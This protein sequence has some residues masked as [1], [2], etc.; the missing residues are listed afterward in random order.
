MKKLRTAV[1]GLGRIGWAFHVPKIAANDGFELVAAVDTNVERLE[2]FKEKYGGNGYTDLKEMLDAENPDLVVIASPTHLHKEQAVIA[3]E[4]GADVFCDKPVAK[5]IDEVH[6][7]DEAAK[8]FGRKLMVYQPHRATAVANTLKKILED[9]KIG[10]VYM[11][12]RANSGYSR[13]NDWQSLKQYG[14]GMLNNYG[15]HFIDQL[16]YIIGEDLS[17][18]TCMCDCVATLGDADDVVKI[19]MKSESG[20]TMD[21]DINQATAYPVTGWTVF[22]KYGTIFAQEE[23]ANEFKVKYII[24]EECPPIEL[25]NSLAAAGRK[26]SQDPPLPWHEEIIPVEADNAIDFYNK[27]YEYFALDMEAFVPFEQ[28]V[29]LMTLIDECHSIAGV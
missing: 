29:K 5:S 6:E 24:P 3:M 13:R 21:L 19:L 12:K 20:I 16:R 26:Y 17:I 10:P 4:H 1:I 22:G 9:G 7:M 14:G 15:A 28:T 23:G 2:E 25:Q 8:R 18:V 27:C 11:V